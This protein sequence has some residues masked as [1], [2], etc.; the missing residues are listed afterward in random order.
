VPAQTRSNRLPQPPPFILGPGQWEGVEGST[1]TLAPFFGAQRTG[2]LL[3]DGVTTSLI[4]GFTVPTGCNAVGVLVIMGSLNSAVS[5]N[6]RLQLG[7]A[8]TVITGGNTPMGDETTAVTSVAFAANSQEVAGR[9]GSGE[10]IAFAPAII[11]GEHCVLRVKRF[12]ADAL[13]TLAGDV[14]FFGVRVYPELVA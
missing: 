6:V 4:A 13:D 14:A 8:D 1:R 3:P 12:G 7:Y 10:P 9:F 2:L 5:G 11:G